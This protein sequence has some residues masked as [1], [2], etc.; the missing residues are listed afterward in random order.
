ML[1]LNHNEYGMKSWI[2]DMP[3]GSGAIFR[4]VIET[5]F[6]H[7]NPNRE[8]LNILEVGVFVGSS[9]I[10]IM[11]MLP[12]NTK[13]VVIDNWSLSSDELKNCQAISKEKLTLPGA[14]QTF[15][16]NIQNAGIK[17][18]VDIIDMASVKALRYL[19]RDKKTFDLIYID[20]SHKTLDVLC[21]LVLSWE[22]LNSGGVLI[23]DDYHWSSMIDTDIIDELDKPKLGINHFLSQYREEYEYISL[24]YRV[25][26]KKL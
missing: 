18:R 22:L 12:K 6:S 17:D 24:N 10:S 11:N 4:A 7:R 19:I 26:L 20:G 13:A 3:L 9:L 23:I 5:E 16:S 21:D 25:M 15:Y 1:P 14:K 2:Y 8:K